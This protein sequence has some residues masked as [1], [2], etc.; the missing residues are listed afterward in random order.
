MILRFD[1]HTGNPNEHVKLDLPDVK[2]LE[3]LIDPKDVLYE[4]LRTASGL[5]ERR[6]RNFEVDKAASRV[7]DYIDDFSSLKRLSAFY[8][9]E[10][11][12]SQLVRNQS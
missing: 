5:S 2:N 4:L 6:R 10:N 8:A 12:I 11:E 3:Q 9:L 7:A 1:S